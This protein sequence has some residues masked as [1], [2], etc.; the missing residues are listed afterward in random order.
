MNTVPLRFPAISTLCF[1]LVLL[2]LPK[3]A[4]GQAPDPMA[5]ATSFNVEHFVGSLGGTGTRDAR[6]TD[7]RF[8][9]PGSIW[10]NSSYIFVSDAYAIRR[11]SRTTG[12]VTTFA[13]AQRPAVSAAPHADHI[14]GDSHYLYN[15]KGTAIYRIELATGTSS[16]FAGSPSNADLVDGI[17]DI[18][19]FRGP[20]AVSG[21]GQFLYA[22]DPGTCQSV[23]HGI[24]RFCVPD[25]PG[26]IRQISLQSGE[27]R[28]IPI[29]QVQS[30]VDVQPS[31]TAIWANGGGLYLGYPNDATGITIGRLVVATQTFET[32]YGF[33]VSGNPFRMPIS[34]Q[35]D[36][37]GGIYFIELGSSGSY[38]PWTGRA[39][40]RIV[41]ATREVSAINFKIAGAANEPEPTD[42]F[43]D[44]DDLFLSDFLNTAVVKLNLSATTADIVAGLPS[45]VAETEN[46]RVPPES[47]SEGIV[48]ADRLPAMK[49]W[50]DGQ[51][52]YLISGFAVYRVSIRS[53]E[54][55]H[56]AGDYVNRG[57]SDG[58][59]SGARFYAP[60]GLWGDGTS[61]YVADI[62]SIRRVDLSTGDV[63]HFAGGTDLGFGPSVQYADGI[64]TSATFNLAT[65]I[66]GDGT[67]LYVNDAS[68]IRRIQI[69]TREVTTFAGVALRPGTNDGTGSSARFGDRCCLF[70]GDG[71]NL[72]VL[73]N[74]T[75]VRKVA[76]ATAEVTTI[77]SLSIGAISNV[78]AMWGLGRQLLFSTDGN[79]GTGAAI[80]S[81]DIATGAIQTLAGDTELYGTEDGPALE[82]RFT[83]I[84]G[85]WTDGS[86]LY[87]ADYGLFRGSAIRVIKPAQTSTS[88]TLT[89]QGAVSWSADRNGSLTTGY[90]LLELSSGSAAPDGVAIF[91]LRQNG[92]LIGETAVAASGLVQSGRIYV[93]VSGAVTTGAAI[94]NPND[95]AAS[96]SFYFTNANGENFRA[97]TL[98][99]PANGQIAAFF[100]QDLFR[101]AISSS[102]PISDARTFTFA[103]SAPIAVVAL[104]GYVNE[105]SEF[106]T[107][108]LPIASIGSPGNQ[109]ITLPHFA[110][111]GGWTTQTLLLNPSDSTMTGVVQLLNPGGDVTFNANYSIATRS[112]VQ[113]AL[114]DNT[115]N[116]RT[117]SIRVLP[118]TGNASPVAST[119]FSFVTGGVTV[120][121]T[122]VAQTGTGHA[123]RVFVE[124][125]GTFGQPGSIRTGIAIANPGTAAANL[126]L[127]LTDTRGVS[128]AP[129]FS[130]TVEARG[131]IALFLH[132]I[133]G[134]K[135][136]AAPFQGVLRVS[137]DSRA[138]LSLIGLRGRYNERDEFLIASMPSINEDVQ[139][140]NSEKVFP[141]IVNGAGYTTQFILI[142]D[143]S[144]AGQLRF[145]SQSGQPLPL[146][147]TP[148]P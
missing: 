27:V 80:V 133:P 39:L 134:F 144:S 72:Y 103:S 51:F 55:M 136:V 141:H 137:T 97:G 28:T 96:I 50:G 142:G 104:R 16:L 122:G 132:E 71:V 11:I 69:A 106:L 105:R 143:A 102:Q 2:T 24:A 88:F 109:S 77:G 84:R 146:T 58:R 124:A 117:G 36:G 138:G 131:Q 121:Q 63:T 8:M 42:L 98:T 33:P 83:G 90:T 94:A 87:V 32:L 35:G 53:G 67:F 85:M 118:N 147:L 140:A 52:I 12:D 23:G 9:A 113:V 116:I 7:A 95:Q 54:T 125:L 129:P 15:A 66:W 110:I 62:H 38:S 92:V 79:M 26:A 65:S 100:D 126:T 46:F 127:E 47:L 115:S 93:Q 91:S 29:P 112:S 119:V 30:G 4:C 86:A 57:D 61:L 3:V 82:A 19:R 135:N 43:I 22:L 111:G 60:S 40:Q 48:P 25:K 14:W 70:W 68:V 59:G 73:D 108:T 123:F 18:A 31:P 45:N 130:A 5:D 89:N 34:F 10:A 6:G 81:M 128:A 20:Y 107:T 64:G 37:R 17:G 56:L 21:D 75:N 49:I 148:L 101:S 139:P 120:T 99:I 145:I 114:S 44:G 13:G 74:R 78:F 76:L 41:L 1:A